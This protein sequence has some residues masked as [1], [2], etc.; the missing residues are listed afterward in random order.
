MEDLVGSAVVQTAPRAMIE[1]VNDIGKRLLADLI[2]VRALGG[3]ITFQLHHELLDGR[4][5]GECGS[6]DSAEGD[7]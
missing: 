5:R 4:L 1:R 7:D 3:G 6:S 2:E